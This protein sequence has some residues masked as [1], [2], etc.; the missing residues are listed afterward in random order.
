MT[1]EQSLNQTVQIFPDASKN[2]AGTALFSF[3]FSDGRGT[4]LPAWGTRE[5]ERMLRLYDRSEENT[6]WQGARAGLIKKWKATPWELTGAKRGRNNARYFQDVFRAAQFGAGWGTFV[7]LVM[8][9]Y[10]RFDGGA[11]IELIAPGNPLKPPTGAITGLAH[12]DSMRCLPTGDPEF[13]VVYYDRNGKLHLMHHTRVIHLLDTPD[14]DEGRPGYGECALS[15]SIAIAQRQIYM[16]RYIV[17]NL[18]DKPSPGFVV[19]TNVGKNERDQALLNYTNEQ[20]RDEM[21]PWGKTF[22]LYSLDP[23][24]P[25]K[26]EPVTFSRPPEK[27]DY[28]VYVELDVNMLA[29]AI[30]MD[31]QELWQLTGG[32]IGSAGQSEILHAK[33][34]GKMYGD[35]LTMLERKLNDA[36]P[37]SAEFAFKTR[38]PYE[39]GERAQTASV[40]A[41][42]VSSVG[43]KMT[44]DEARRLLA[45]QV[46]AFKDAVTDE[47]GEIA[48]L[49]DVDVA[50]EN[51]PDDD[52]QLDDSTPAPTEGQAPAEPVT[53]TDQRAAKAIQ[54]TRL[55]FEADFEDA[56][57]A[58]EINAVSQRG[59]ATIVRGLVS[60]YG[61]AAYIDGLIDGGV[62]PELIGALDPDEEDEIVALVAN[63]SGYVTAFAADVYERGLSD[64]EKAI[65]PAMWWN[66]SLMPFFE[67]GRLSADKNGYYEWVLGATEEHCADCNRL[68]GQIHRFKDW[69]RTNWK[70][71]SDRLSCKGFNCKCS[72]VKAEK[73]ARARGKF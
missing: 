33:S 45:N 14:G 6:L 21:P 10:L 18:D 16:G 24:A 7:A 25:A 3:W 2:G 72:L 65:K 26:L 5:R 43:A 51:A 44:P 58:A 19:A 63:Q 12:L 49:D 52:V 57:K 38:D 17:Q 34:Q 27:F 67:A 55:D 61:R 59:F 22:W 69:K 9:D 53:E 56:L 1:V 39:A 50:P 73:G 4:I 71:Q 42:F 20:G 48:R 32:N 64:A 60:K 37:E 30:G 15:R 40:W 66:K 11:Y 47:S 35:G 8:R 31:V 54:S 23:T 29:L 13:P 41:G 36:I 70:P 62:T 68:S 28:K 46:E